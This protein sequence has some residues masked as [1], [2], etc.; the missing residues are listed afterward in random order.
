MPG[1]TETK[2]GKL[3]LGPHLQVVSQCS[4]LRSHAA[5]I[6]ILPKATKGEE[7]PQGSFKDLH[8]AFSLSFRACRLIVVCTKVR[9][10]SPS[11]LPLPKHHAHIRPPSGFPPHKPWPS[12]HPFQP[13]RQRPRDSCPGQDSRA[14][15]TRGGAACARRHWRQPGRRRC[16]ARAL[17]TTGRGIGRGHC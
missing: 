9:L 6:G 3:I 2:V 4:T 7:W 5:S 10:I 8:A 13:G 11:A 1:Q 17:R 12:A 15:P 16:R 14:S